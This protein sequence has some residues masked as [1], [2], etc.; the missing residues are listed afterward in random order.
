[1]QVERITLAP[2]FSRREAALALG[3]TVR[4]ISHWTT[5]GILTV[6]TWVSPGGR[7]YRHYDAVEVARLRESM[8]VD[9]LKVGEA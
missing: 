4:T 5:K 8:G 3:V 9:A 1:M 7:V 2:R 6:T